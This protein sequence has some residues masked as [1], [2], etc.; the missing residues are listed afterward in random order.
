MDAFTAMIQNGQ[1][2]LCE[3][4]QAMALALAVLSGRR[5]AKGT[6]F[7]CALFHHAPILF[8]F[9][10]LFREEGAE[11]DGSGRGWKEG[12]RGGGKLRPFEDVGVGNVDE[13]ERDRYKSSCVQVNQTRDSFHFLSVPGKDPT[14]P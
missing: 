12:G 9:L 3:N 1:R 4:F 13:R 8:F 6:L 10:I 2:E 7:P 5:Q 14:T 11:D